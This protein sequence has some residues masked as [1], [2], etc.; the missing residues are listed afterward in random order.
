M[1]RNAPS[2]LSLSRQVLSLALPALGALIAEPIFVLIDSAMVGHLGTAPLAGL[3]VASTV[4]QTV[5]Y[6]FVF[7][8]FSTTTRAAQAYGRRDIPAAA[9]TGIQSV[10]LALIIG[11]LLAMILFF[12]A[13]WILSFFDASPEALPHAHAYL[14]TSA[15]GVVGMF[16]VMA[17]TGTLRGMHDTRAALVVS[18]SGAVVNVVLNAFF[19]YGMGLGVAGSG[20]GTSVTQLLMAVAL[21]FFMGV[22]ARNLHVR[23]SNAEVSAASLRSQVT[24]RPSLD[25]VR[26]SVRDGAWLLVRTIALRIALMST[27]FV[28]AQ[29]GVLAVAAH[30]IAW[31][32]W[33]FTAYAL[34]ALAIAGQT[35]FASAA[36]AATAVDHAAEPT[37]EPETPPTPAAA[38]GVG[39]GWK[40]SDISQTELLRLLTRWGMWMGVI[41]GLILAV[42]TPFIPRFFSTDPAV[43]NAAVAPLLIACVTMPIA[44]V[45][46]L[47][48]GIMM[49]ADRAAF[50][51]KWGM[52]LLLVHLP[53]LWL[54]AYVGSSLSV[55][56]AL[57][58]LWVEYGFVFIGGR[59]VY[60]WLGSRDL[61][62]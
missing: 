43:V 46:F 52:L 34:D 62:S 30:H 41:L 16:V 32:V 48:D 21:V 42:M 1:P 59:A 2:S 45:V 36:A 26:A 19:I 44:A 22:H 39:E 31:M 8:L 14:Q 27:L 24:L 23:F 13:S 58:L 4:V 38:D 3:G 37:R 29:L 15:P 56:V 50:L 35:L 20:L 40:A 57:A 55:P 10:Y 25:G 9:T 12:G 18:I 5:V 28:A 54:V 11:S 6:L 49:G 17:A 61:R 47:Y 51:A 7:L 60:L 53:A 33:G